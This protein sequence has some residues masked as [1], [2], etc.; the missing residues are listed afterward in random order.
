MKEKREF[1]MLENADDRTVELLSGVPVL[2][3]EEKKRMLAMSK[4]KLDNM[5]R[6]NNISMNK[7]GAEVSGVERYNRPKWQTF[8]SV[9]ACFV[10]VGGIAGTVMLLG[11]NGKD[12]TKKDNTAVE[13]QTTTDAAVTTTAPVA[14]DAIL[15]IPVTTAP[16]TTTEPDNIVPELTEE[17][18]VKIASEGIRDEFYIDDILTG[19]S[20][21]IDENDKISYGVFSVDSGDSV[22]IPF[23]RVI[24]SRF[25]SI[26]DIK[27]LT[28]DYLTDPLI[29]D[30]F[31]DI[32][33]IS[34]LFIEKDGK[35]YT[36]QS[37]YL[38]ATVEFISDPVIT[39]YD[40]TTFYATATVDTGR[41]TYGDVCTL[42]YQ[43]AFVDGKWKVSGFEVVDSNNGTD[44]ETETEL[45]NADL[46]I[47]ILEDL[48]VLDGL[49]AGSGVEVENDI[50]KTIVTDEGF[51]YVYYKVSDD[52][53]SENFKNSIE[54]IKSWVDNVATG[55]AREYYKWIC[56]EENAMFREFDGELYYL[57]GCSETIFRWFGEPKIKNVQNGSFDILVKCYCNDDMIQNLTVN[58]VKNGYGWKI[59]KCVLDESTLR[60]ATEEE[61]MEY[62][63]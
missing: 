43:F 25:E 56:D 18:L 44:S 60:P 32:F 40:G 35:L 23:Y 28:A 17:E 53:A 48:R 7:E 10:L 33:G 31:A 39:G 45:P 59:N 52:F 36:S 21:D 55:E 37:M 58:V 30:R 63:Y 5:N 13:V 12:S 61:I 24:D 26:D 16:V 50:S 29:T 38:P 1:N 3:D 57:Y 8:A 6:E 15:T 62:N 2:T 22:E 14:T 19:F 27:A 41:G 4:K 42:R 9:A 34:P 51:E 46:A 49:R 54:D 11:R 20:V 47:D